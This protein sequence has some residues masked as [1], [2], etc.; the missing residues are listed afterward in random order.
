MPGKTNS[1]LVGG[2]VAAGV[3]AFASFIPVAGSCI[4]CL[5]YIAAGLVAVWHYVETHRLAISGG[6][7]ARMGAG[8]G[9][10]A[11]LVGTLISFLFQVL[12]LLPGYSEGLQRLSESGQLSEEQLEAARTA[13]ESSLLYVGVAVIGLIVGAS[14]GAIGGTIGA[15]VFERGGNTP[16]GNGGPGGPREPVG[17]SPQPAGGPQQTPAERTTSRQPASADAGESS[18]RPPE[19]ERAPKT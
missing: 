12:G 14:L 19:E 9:A 15:S 11:G 2:V 10:V 13:L 6:T 5:A 8:A 18:Y 17:A 3:A 1:I 4:G 7:G 16:G